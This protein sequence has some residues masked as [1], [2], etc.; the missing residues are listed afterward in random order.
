MNNGEGRLVRAGNT[1]VIILVIAIVVG[2]L[3]GAWYLITTHGLAKIA[4]SAALVV[5]LVI[6]I[7]VAFR[8]RNWRPTVIV[9]LITV[10]AAVIIWAALNNMGY[11]PA[12]QDNLPVQTAPATVPVV[13]DPTVPAPPPAPTEVSPPPA[14]PAAAPDPCLH[15]VQP[16]ENLYRIGL[17]YG[18]PFEKLAAW[19]GIP[20]PSKIGVGQ[21]L[22]VCPP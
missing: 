11:G 12:G 17:K 22:R 10:V 15:T 3:A 19:N 2:L 14:A 8:S 20:D 6:T 21:V 16:G 13:A 9:F 1:I 7:L 5:G 4:G 18:H